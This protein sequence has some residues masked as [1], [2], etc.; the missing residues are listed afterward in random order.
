VA[1][2]LSTY[3]KDLPSRETPLDARTLNAWGGLVEE[4]VDAAQAAVG[5]VTAIQDDIEANIASW[6]TSTPAITAALPWLAIQTSYTPIE[7]K[8]DDWWAAVK[9]GTAQAIMIGDSITEGTG[10]TSADRRWQTLVQAALSPLG[11][12]WPFIPAWPQSTAPGF[13]VSQTGGV[14]RS[15][16]L[17]Q[18]WGLGWRTAEIFDDTGEVTFTFTG[19]SFRIMY[20]KA[21][22]AGVMT[23]Q[24]D[25]A[26]PVVVD[27]NS[28]TA[29]PSSNGAT[30]ASGALTDGPH[31][32]TLRRSPTSIAGQSVWVQGLLTYRDDESA[33]VRILDSSRHGIS[34]AYL[35]SDALR[36]AA[37]TGSSG[38]IV[39]AGGADLV[40]VALGTN[41]YG[42]TPAATFGANI[43]ALIDALRSPAPALAFDGSIALVGTYL[44]Q[45]R[46]P[47]L[48]QE[49]Q[50]QLV[51]IA[52][53]DPKIAYFDLRRRM[54]DVPS[55]ASDAKGLGL[56][57]DALHPSDAGNQWIARVMTDYLLP[58]A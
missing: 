24:I 8:L 18:R 23:V 46:N 36:L 14:R 52:Q 40:V 51:A 32:V 20:P 49:Y 29:P 22:T 33:G 1:D 10:T 42:N 35:T 45:G 38:S 48:W 55:P 34:S 11:P 16:S 28:S 50:R 53:G 17:S 54:P 27:T 47:T 5:Q 39:G 9:T 4:Q 37:L 31:T 13:P 15:T 3:W 26:T 57:A 25:G 44:G 21:S 2:D 30:W 7:E 12:V 41:D 19:T 58:R 43:R 6:A 56:Y